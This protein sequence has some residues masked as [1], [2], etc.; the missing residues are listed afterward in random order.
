MGNTLHQHFDPGL[1]STLFLVLS[2][3]GSSTVKQFYLT[4]VDFTTIIYFIPYVYLFYSYFV[5]MRRKELPFDLNGILA[6]LFGFVATVVAII[7]SI[8]PPDDVKSV[9]WHET[10]MI[11][12]T[13]LMVLPAII[14]YF[15][16]HRKIPAA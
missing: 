4:L 7:L 5:F 15:R 16:A 3:K 11:G 2:F 1:L 13:L 14:L 6:S 10:R 12:G 9:W 8:L